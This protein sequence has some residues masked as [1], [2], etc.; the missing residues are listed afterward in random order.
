[1]SADQAKPTS[2]SKRSLYENT[3][4][5]AGMFDNIKRYIV[6]DEGATQIEYALIAIIVSCAAVTAMSSINTMIG[7]WY[8][9]AINNLAS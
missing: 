6:D 8:W 9:S 3:S 1:M 2:F 7:T 4:K 5:G